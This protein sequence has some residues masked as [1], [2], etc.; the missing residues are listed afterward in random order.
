MKPLSSL[1]TLTTARSTRFW[2]SSY[3]STWRLCE[4]L[5]GFIIFASLDLCACGYAPRSSSSTRYTC[6][7][8]TA[9][10]GISNRR[11]APGCVPFEAMLHAGSVPADVR[12]QTQPPRLRV[13][14]LTAP[15]RRGSA[16]YLFTAPP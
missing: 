4:L 1:A 5:A 8:T 15:S 7:A 11:S 14:P 2:A 10:I 16:L 12:T 9:R 13:M 6:S 3:S